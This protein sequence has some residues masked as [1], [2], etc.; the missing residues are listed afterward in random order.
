MLEAQGMQ[1]AF[2]LADENNQ[3]QQS[4]QAFSSTPNAPSSPSLFPHT[5]LNMCQPPYLHE[6][7]QGRREILDCFAPWIVV[8][9]A[10]YTA[11]PNHASR[12]LHKVANGFSRAFMHDKLYN[13]EAGAIAQMTS[14]RA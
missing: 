11:W 2:P 7:E 4:V 5:A 3:Q 12:L 6:G 13:K 14:L 1:H 10:K 9:D 8:D